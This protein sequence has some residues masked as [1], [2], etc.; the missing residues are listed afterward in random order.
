MQWTRSRTEAYSPPLAINRFNIV[1]IRED[2][3]EETTFLLGITHIGRGTPLPPSNA[4]IDTYTFL[5]V[6]KVTQI[7]CRAG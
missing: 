4:Q 6:K 3:P 7:V 1:I 5:E 2:A